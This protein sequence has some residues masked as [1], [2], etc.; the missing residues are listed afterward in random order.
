MTAKPIRATFAGYRPVPS[1]SVGALTFE[2]PLE[3]LDAA[4]AALGGTPLPSRSAW[5]AIVRL[6]DD[7]PAAG[8]A[9]REDAGAT[10]SLDPP[11]AEPK[12]TPAERYAGKTEGQ[13]AVVRAGLLCEDAEFQKWITEKH[14]YVWSTTQGSPN[15]RV[16]ETVR[17]LCGVPSRAGIGTDENAMAAFLALEEAYRL[18][19][20]SPAS[21]G[22]K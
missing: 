7:R 11:A 12:P 9:H 21:T 16:A 2:V 4:V 8:A 19:G 20:Y 17:I 14:F 3:E 15:H 22:R 10:P 18:R 13:K 5:V 1:R 6:G